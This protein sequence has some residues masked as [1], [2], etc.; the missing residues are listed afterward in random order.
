MENPNNEPKEVILTITLSTEG[1]GVNGPI[2]NEPLALW[3]IEKAKDI[4]K[5]H[6]ILANQPKITTSNRNIFGFKK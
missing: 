6:N 3:L 5:A 4:I 2:T 1:V